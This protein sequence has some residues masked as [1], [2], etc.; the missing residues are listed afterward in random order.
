MLESPSDCKEIKPVHPKGNQSWI[1]IGRTDAEAPIL[2]PPDV[3]NWLIGKDPDDGK[4][5]GQEKKWVAEDE[6]VGWY[7]WLNGHEFEQI[8]GDSEGQGGL[9]CCSAR[10]R[11]ESDFASEQQLLPADME[12][13]LEGCGENFK[14]VQKAEGNIWIMS[15]WVHGPS[16]HSMTVI[17]VCLW[18]SQGR[19][20]AYSFISHFVAWCIDCHCC[21]VAQCL[22][23]E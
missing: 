23:N 18:V 1:F 3:K 11:K 22:M 17:R 13:G 20:K 15:K 12:D 10:D 8:L 16:G 19:E 14:L 6:M 4:D 7:H 2:W 5:W 21:L 9:T